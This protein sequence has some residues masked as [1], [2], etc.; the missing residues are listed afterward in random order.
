MHV[1]TQ[2]TPFTSR[3]GPHTPALVVRRDLAHLFA[4]WHRVRAVAMAAKKPATQQ[5]KCDRSRSPQPLASPASRSY[6]TPSC[7]LLT[8]LAD[9]YLFKG[10]TCPA[11]SPSPIRRE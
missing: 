8:S 2:V 9:D 4:G 7:C 5:E 1:I 6:L 10:A 3:E 11:E